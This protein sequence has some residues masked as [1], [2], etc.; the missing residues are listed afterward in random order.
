MVRTSN[1]NTDGAGTKKRTS[2]SKAD[3]KAKTKA[4]AK[5]K[6]N[7]NANASAKAKTMSSSP[8]SSPASWVDNGQDLNK[9]LAETQRKIHEQHRKLAQTAMSDAKELLAV[10][11]ERIKR[12]YTVT[13]KAELNAIAETLLT[14]LAGQD[15][16][17]EGFYRE[18]AS[19]NAESHGA[20]ERVLEGFA[21]DINAAAKVGLEAGRAVQIGFTDEKKSLQVLQL[22]LGADRTDPTVTTLANRHTSA[23]KVAE[24]INIAPMDKSHGEGQGEA[25]GDDN[26]KP[27]SRGR[28]SRIS[29]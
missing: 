25:G 19:V 11:M 14:K 8:P 20:F 7:T 22:A 26:G 24:E 16:L 27:R 2:S 1:T 17:I 15:T 23:S 12:A 9:M 3:P 21:V 5:A 29:I 13:H 4:N 28:K 6:P 10:V 18:L